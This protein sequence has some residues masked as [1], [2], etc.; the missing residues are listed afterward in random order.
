MVAPA[1]GQISESLHAQSTI[2]SQFYLSIF[3]LAYAVG[4]FPLGPLS[5]T[6]GR[7]Y[8]LQIAN[9]LYLV[10][11]L[12]CGFAHTTTQMLVFRFLSGLGGSAPLTIGG[13]VIG[14][15][16]QAH[17]RGS[18]VAVYSLAPLLGPA[19]GWVCDD[20]RDFDSADILCQPDRRWI[21]RSKHHVAVDI[22]V[23]YHC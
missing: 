8:V 11:N 14:D 12:A 2:E 18:A 23:D 5:E 13:G 1:L 15:M 19:I 7:V 17:E 22:L 10:F 9:L 20:L 6:Y 21:C 4:P 16:F 3:L